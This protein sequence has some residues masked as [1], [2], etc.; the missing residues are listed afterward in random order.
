M[1][2]CHFD[3]NWPVCSQTDLLSGFL[4][5]FPPPPTPVVWRTSGNS[6][7]G[8]VWSGDSNGG[9]GVEGAELGIMQQ[10]EVGKSWGRPRE[11]AEDAGEK[12]GLDSLAEAEKL[13][14]ICRSARA[15]AGP[16]GLLW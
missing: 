8:Q 13:Y 15:T 5:L 1:S 7:K 16:W 9:G 11:R 4:F 6:G 10:E 12:P 3:Y 14:P 2:C